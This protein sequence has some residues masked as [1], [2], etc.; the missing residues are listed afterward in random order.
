M[1]TERMLKTLRIVA[2]YHNVGGYSHAARGLLAAALLAGFTVEAVES[3]TNEVHALRLDGAPSQRQVP[4]FPGKPI[5]TCQL[6]ELQQ[7]LRT[8]VSHDAPTIL[9]GN[10][11]MMAEYPEYCAGPRIGYT[12]LESDTLQPQWAQACR[13]VDLLLAPSSW[14]VETLRRCVPGVPVELLPICVDE[15]LWSPEGLKRMISPGQ[16]PFLFLSIFSTCERKGWRKTIQAFA[17][18]FRGENVGLVLKPTRVAEVE[19]LADWA[20]SMGA[21]IEIIKGELSDYEMACLYRACD[22]YVSPSAE[23]FGVPLVEAGMCGLPSVALAA[24]GAA[25]IVTRFNGYPVEVEWEPCV[26]QLPQIYPSSHKWPTCTVGSLRAAMRRAREDANLRQVSLDVQSQAA[27]D[28]NRGAVAFRLNG[29]KLDEV[30][31]SLLPVLHARERIP[32]FVAVITTHNNLKST[33]RLAQSLLSATSPYMIVIADDG[34]TDDTQ[35]WADSHGF[36]FVRCNTGGNVSRNRQIA[37]NALKRQFNFADDPHVVFFDNDVEVSG[38]WWESLSQVMQAR[39]EIGILAPRKVYG[40]DTQASAPQFDAPTADTVQNVGNR[41]YFHCGSFPVLLERPLV[42][43]DY[44]ES[45][46]MVVRPKVWRSLEWDEQF[47]IFY[48]DVDYCLQARAAGWEV[49]ATNA[50]TVTHHAHT[51][52]H[53]RAGQAE[54]SRMRFL[55]KWRNSL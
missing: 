33:N 39:P 11:G 7:A 10:P 26:G 13:N 29:L 28:F 17:E 25:D 4:R 45:A 8:T 2:P 50:A 6:E 47:P 48:E 12:M 46:C 55:K 54:V 49:C 42:Y 21:G 51:T 18:E 31:A 24:G 9:M 32:P 22:V 52:S 19:E 37:V 44:V 5:P 36:L 43:P 16:S 41:L 53:T 15:R 40:A 14:C 38:D 34:S 27:L 3:E 35:D 30:Q 20:R 23:G 1:E